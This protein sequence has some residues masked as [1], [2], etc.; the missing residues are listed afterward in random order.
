MRRLCILGLSV[1]LTGCVATGTKVSQD[2]LTHFA[3]GQTLCAD[4]VADLGPPT[5]ETLRSDKT[6]QLTY[7]YSQMQ[8]NPL[9]FLPVAGAF[10]RSGS[11]ENTAVLI[12]CDARGVLV[13]YELQQGQ[14]TTGTRFVSGGRQ[15]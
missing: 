8:V 13:T 7:S 2:R 9:S 10:I 3:E 6:R 12:E 5:Q 11:Q 14:S 15:R 1:A 4:M